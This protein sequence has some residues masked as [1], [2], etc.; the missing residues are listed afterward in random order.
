[1]C[2]IGAVS[3]SLWTDRRCV[4]PRLRGLPLR[5]SQKDRLLPRPPWPPPP[6]S[7]STLTLFE[8]ALIKRVRGDDVPPLPPP[9]GGD[10]A[11]GSCSWPFARRIGLL[12]KSR[13]SLSSFFSSSTFSCCFSFHWRASACSMTR[14][15]DLKA[16]TRSDL[17]AP[18]T[19]CRCYERNAG[20]HRSCSATSRFQENH[21]ASAS[22]DR[23]CQAPAS[24]PHSH[25]AAGRPSIL[26]DVQ[27]GST[28]SRPRALLTVLPG[29]AMK[30][31][32]EVFRRE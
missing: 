3:H 8:P 22:A 28:L 26:H 13:S 29:G 24:Q 31:C 30:S 19:I 14:M 9:G 5:I 7:A 17:K 2:D 1:M 11:S 10:G 12:P 15:S 32:E 6:L 16:P 25:S 4:L 18:A 27:P 23:A 21:S 20:A